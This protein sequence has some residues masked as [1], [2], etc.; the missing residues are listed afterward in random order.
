MWVKK[1]RADQEDVKALIRKLDAYQAELYPAESNHLDDPSILLQD[2]V[3]MIGVLVP[4]ENRQDALA[5]IGAVKYLDGYAEIKRM[6][7][8]ED[9]R[10]MGIARLLL[11]QLEYLAAARSRSIVRL[12]TGIHQTAAI[13]LYKRAG[14]TA[15]PPFG[16]YFEDP[17]SVFMEKAIP[18]VKTA[19]HISSFAEGYSDDPV[20]VLSKRLIPDTNL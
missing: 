17:L 14:F 19:L 9:H 10:K 16:A 15:I 5:G 12:E 13:G 18:P 2:N 20:V 4:G 11:Q 3:D 8:S 7:V 6:Y 1:V